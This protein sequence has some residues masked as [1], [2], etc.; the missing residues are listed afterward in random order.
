MNCFVQELLST[1]SPQKFNIFP[2]KIER[3]P[4]K[5]F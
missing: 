2:F 1:H 4:I 5:F 3:N